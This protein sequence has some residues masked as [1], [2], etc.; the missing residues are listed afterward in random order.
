MADQPQVIQFEGATHVFPADFTPEEISTALKQAHPLRLPGPTVPGT[1]RTGLPGIAAP[2]NVLRQR[3]RELAAAEQTLKQ[4]FAPDTRG[5]GQSAWDQIRGLNP[6]PAVEQWWSGP[7]TIA[8]LP[9]PEGRI[10]DIPV[11]AP[12]ATAAGQ[13]AQ[14]NVPGAIGTLATGLPIQVGLSALSTPEGRAAAAELPGAVARLPGDIALKIPPKV[15]ERLGRFTGGATGATVGHATGIPGAGI[16]GA[17]VGKGVGAGLGGALENL[18]A[19]IQF[20]RAI[21]ARQ[22]WPAGAAEPTPITP[23]YQALQARAQAAAETP[24]PAAAPET[25][26]QAAATP[27][28]WPP[29]PDYEALM[30]APAEAPAEAPVEPGP[31]D[32]AIQDLQGQLRDKYTQNITQ[33]KIQSYDELKDPANRALVDQL[34]KQELRRIAKKGPEAPAAAPATEAAAAAPEISPEQAELLDG[35]TQSYSDGKIQSYNKIPKDA[36]AFRAQIDDLAGRITATRQA[37]AAAPPAP[38]TVPPPAYQ[39]SVPPGTTAAD[40]L[41]QEQAARRAAAA[42]QAPP[43]ESPPI[44]QGGPQSAPAVPAGA[45]VPETQPAATPTAAE[46]VE[47][48][49]AGKRATR[50]ETAQQFADYLP[51]KGVTAEDIAA[52]NDREQLLPHARDAG[53]DIPKSRDAFTKLRNAIVKEML[54]RKA[55]AAPPPAIPPVQPYPPP[56]GWFS[57]SAIQKLIDLQERRART[58][59]Q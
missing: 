6:I 57:P 19:S 26:P 5:F 15:A 17:F 33:Q 40:L 56:G 3:G 34:A 59:A 38:A 49:K 22:N 54:A 4:T 11:A 31:G 45:Q 35:L 27:S 46:R 58:A 53:L 14:G 47:A 12:V 1:E 51:T 44:A 52:M 32:T 55:A 18:Q 30:R 13:A 50:T 29:A 41:R 25:P 7:K 36:T 10:T 24:A 37:Q 9:A 39:G 43:V 8:N 16:A 2:P 20:D 42:S 23:E 21:K 48:I 28:S